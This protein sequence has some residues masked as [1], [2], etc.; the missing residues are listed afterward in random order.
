[1]N[2]MAYNLKRWHTL[3]KARANAQRFKPPDRAA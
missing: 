3:T 1:M 2:A